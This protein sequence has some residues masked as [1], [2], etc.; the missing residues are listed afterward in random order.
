MFMKIGQVSG[1]Y[2]LDEKG[3]SYWEELR[4]WLSGKWP[5]VPLYT[6]TTDL[7]ECVTSISRK[8]NH[9][10]RKILYT[11]QGRSQK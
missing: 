7:G 10:C 6:G 11:V 9:L 2:Y 5:H 3:I 4:L 1:V 8:K